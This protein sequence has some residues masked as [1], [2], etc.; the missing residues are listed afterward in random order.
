MT[1][2]TDEAVL[3]AWLAET[4]DPA[5]SSAS[6]TRLDGGHSSGA[7]RVVVV[8]GDV[9]RPVVL[10]APSQPS[11]VFRQNPAREARIIDAVGRMGA[12]VPQVFAV[13]DGTRLGQPGFVMQYVE[14][15]SLADSTPG[16]CHD[17]PWL[18]GIGPDAQRAVWNSFHDALAALHRVDATK[19]PDARHGA[20]GLVGVIA[21]WREALLDGA[22]AESVPRQLA[23]LDWL[24][25]HL[26]P[27]ADDEPAVCM[28]DARLANCLV[29]E[30]EVCALVDF[31][32]AYVGNPAADLAY[33]LFFE[34]LQRRGA[35][36]TLP[37]IPAADTTWARWAEMTGRDADHRDYW[38]AFAAMILTV[39]ATR[40]MI[41]WGLSGASGGSVEL[42][43]PLV[44]E[45]EAV[46][47]QAAAR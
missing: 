10:K 47:E 26:P 19:V 21:Y 38:T 1:A 35:S 17:D 16:G 28:G 31:E 6:V 30:H 45:W 2:G 15:R 14:G 33:S 22:A 8:I 24:R 23:L 27:G 44:S 42:D 9:S 41:Q 32:I 18:H 43:N 3:A 39:T 5:I 13:D 40:A 12:P 4:V 29:V 46:V 34:M 11:V 36:R 20:R 7:W 37:G 25:D